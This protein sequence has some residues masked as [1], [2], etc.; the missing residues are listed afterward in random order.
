MANFNPN[1]ISY[2]GWYLNWPGLDYLP[3]LPS[4]PPPQITEVGSGTGLEVLKL[5]STLWEKSYS[6]GK[7]LLLS[8]EESWFENIINRQ[9][10]S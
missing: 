8:E 5:D 6:K 1:S 3:L 4:H 2:N 10:L 7:W 9:K